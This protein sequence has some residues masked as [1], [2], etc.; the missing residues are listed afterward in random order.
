MMVK[1]QVGMQPQ[2]QG[3]GRGFGYGRAVLEEP[4]LAQSPQSRGTIQWAVPAAIA[5]S[6]TLPETDR[7]CHAQYSLR[8]HDGRFSNRHQKRYL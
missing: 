8:R 6:S 2:T 1:D 7:R 4:E 5:A 3:P